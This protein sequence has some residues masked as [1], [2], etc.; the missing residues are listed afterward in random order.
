MRIR[1]F[2]LPRNTADCVCRCQIAK[3][4]NACSSQSRFALSTSTGTRTGDL[5]ACT[6]VAQPI[7]LPRSLDSSV[8][9]ATGYGMDDRGVGVRVPEGSLLH[10]VQTGSGVHPTSYSMG[11]G[12]S[13]PGGETNHSPPTSA[14]VET[15]WIYTSTPPY[16]FVA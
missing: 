14:E 10:V 4:C 7:T 16:A 15:M 8:G 9:T 6:T 13:F 11:I 2:L 5:L 3:W 12:S 1:D